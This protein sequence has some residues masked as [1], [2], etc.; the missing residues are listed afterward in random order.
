MADRFP[1]FVRKIL[2]TLTQ[3]GFEA[4]VVGGAVRDLLMK[5]EVTDWDFTTNATPEQIQ[6]LFQTTFY[7]NEFGTVG[8]PYRD[9]I[10]EITTFRT[11]R[12]YKDRRHPEHVSWGKTLDEDLQRRDFTINAMAL[13]LKGDIFD[14]Y[15][16]QKDLHQ[17]FIRAVGV[18]SERFQ[19]DALRL[20]RAIRIATELAF[21]IEEKTFQAVKKNAHLINEI[22]KERV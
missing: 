19:E 9:H 15:Q 6:S 8:I 20:M 21:T 7:E 14:P 5:K 16:G 22:A 13:D 4:Y 12:G 11:E 3:A 2:S 18:P 17:K 1:P 10:Y